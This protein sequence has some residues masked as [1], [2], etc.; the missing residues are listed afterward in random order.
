MSAFFDQL[1]ALDGATGSLYQRLQNLIRNAIESGMLA[2]NEPI[3]P[4]RSLAEKLSISRVTVR[5]ALEGLVADGFLVRRQGAG[6]FVAE[7]VEKSFSRLSSF[8]EDMAVRGLVT[9]S[10]WL[11]HEAG[12]VTPEEAMSLGLAPG[13]GVYR[14]H[15]IRFA[16]DQPMALE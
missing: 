9:R 6:T 13:A 11:R 14:F 16:D 10:V 1:P 7:R 3:P 15:R 8:S 2:V 12:T 5:K 4:E